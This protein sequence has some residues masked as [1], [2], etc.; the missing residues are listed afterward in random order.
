MRILIVEDEERIA[1]FIK[2]GLEEESYAVDVVADGSDALDWV[3]SAEYDLILLDVMLPGLNGFEVTRILRDRGVVTPILMLTAR[4]DI[5]DRVKGLDSGADDY[6]PKP[7]AFKELLARIRALVR[8]SSSTEKVET[9]L[10]I[11]DLQL[12]IVTHV[13]RRGRRDIELT[14]KEYALLEY[15]MRH[16]RRP[17]SRTLIREAVWGYDYFGASNVVDVYVRHLRQKLEDHGESPLIH[18][19]RGIGYKIDDVE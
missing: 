13:A 2:T 9:T 3:A 7:F 17:L 4:D 1:R 8:R 12:D 15:L 11:G 14:A 19:V 10:E 6:L 16:P 5:D 18:T